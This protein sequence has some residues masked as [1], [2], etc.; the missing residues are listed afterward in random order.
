MPS[1]RVFRHLSYLLKN[2]PLVKNSALNKE[3]L[4]NKIISNTNSIKPRAFLKVVTWMKKMCHETLEFSFETLEISIR[5]LK[6][7]LENTS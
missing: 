7:Y 2:N 4:E 1:D 6:Q 5:I 3:T